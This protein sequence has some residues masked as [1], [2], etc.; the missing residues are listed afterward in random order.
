MP[1]RLRVA[2]VIP[3]LFV[4]T[5]QAQ[6]LCHPDES[7][8]DAF[9]N[10]I[11]TGTNREQIYQKTVAVCQA[12]CCARTWC[13]AIE[14]RSGH[15]NKQCNLLEVSHLDG[16]NTLSASS[17]WD[18]YY[19]GPNVGDYTTNN[20]P[21]CAGGGLA[22]TDSWYTV[23]NY[24][25]VNR[26]LATYTGYS[27]DQCKTECCNTWWCRSFEHA[28]GSSECHL[29]SHVWYEVASATTS[30]VDYYQA[31]ANEPPSP[32]MAPLTGYVQPALQRSWDDAVST[33]EGL[34]G[35]LAVPHNQ[36]EWDA[37][38]ASRV[39]SNSFWIGIY[40]PDGTDVYYGMDGTYTWSTFTNWHTN[41]PTT[42]TA[43]QCVV[44]RW[45][46]GHGWVDNTCTT[47]RNFICQNLAPPMPALP[48]SPPAPPQPPPAP[49]GTVVALSCQSGIKLENHIYGSHHICCPATCGT[50][51]GIGCD[52][53]DG[54]G[55]TQTQSCCAG[56]IT[57]AG[58][59]CATLQDTGCILPN[60]PP[61][62]S[63][64]PRPPPTPLTPTHYYGQH[65]T[66]WGDVRC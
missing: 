44:A 64:P 7:W 20:N 46:T 19:K 48:P 16:T 10:Q 56:D 42:S 24:G 58:I 23:S 50:C 52:N 3:W 54:S 59:T 65:W 2:L 34:G 62:P 45:A 63:L 13:I 41:R 1:P 40:S 15:V 6:L 53:R 29:K 11:L 5:V 22:T 12:E 60:S 51:G 49:P 31:A 26:D 66:H 35:A 17:G 55:A 37:M 25:I 33:C 32:P 47:L 27:V 9:V 28:A 39:T 43:R 4:T 38:V 30:G 61:P 21:A 36:A 57:T 14:Y 18:Y 8:S